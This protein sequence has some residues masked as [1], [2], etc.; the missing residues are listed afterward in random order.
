[1][2]DTHI[3]LLPG[4]DDGPPDMDVALHM[5]RMLVEDGI[6]AVSVTP[7]MREGA[8][9]NEGPTV[10]KAV[11]QLRARLKKRKIPL[12]IYPGSEVHLTVRMP[13]RIADGRLMTY[14]DKKKHV[15]LE[16][17]HR[18]RPINLEKTIFDLNVAGVVTVLAHPERIRF[19]QDEPEQYE[20]MLRMG[21]IGQMTA[22][23]LTGQF[24]KTIQKLSEEWVQRRMVHVLATDAHDPDYRVPIMS[25]ARARWI[26]LAGEE[27]A[28]RATE[29]YPKALLTGRLIKLP[30]VLPPQKKTGFFGR[31]FGR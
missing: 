10:L 27:S 5:A 14:A 21:A 17:P 19:F 6:T 31:L 18:N 15:L 28:R 22:G 13:E 30:P 1:M 3:H 9:M 11:E 26:E 2:I 12:Q 16:C 29:S 25:E 4:I 24:G 23:S 20:E 7:H 8:Y